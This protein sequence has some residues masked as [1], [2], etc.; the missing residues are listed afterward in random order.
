MK[1]YLGTGD[2]PTPVDTVWAR[3]DDDEA[4]VW[5]AVRDA[6]RAPGQMTSRLRR[7]VISSQS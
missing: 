7:S 2:N 1:M 4:D 5:Q 3:N 6:V